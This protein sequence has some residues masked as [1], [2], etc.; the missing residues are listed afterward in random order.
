MPSR[1][2]IPPA[3][4]SFR[5]PFCPNPRCPFH[6]RPPTGPWPVQ[7]R[8]YRPVARRPGRIRRFRCRPCGAWFSSS[9][10][11]DDYW[12]KLPDLAA[13]LYHLIADGKGLRQSA[14]ALKVSP[15]T[16]RRRQRW[17]AGQALLLHVDQE[18]RLHGR[19]DEPVVLDGLRS[20]AGSQF[21]M[22]ELNTALTTDTAFW[23]ALDPIPLRRSGRMTARQRQQRRRRDGRLGRPDPR[24]RQRAT[25]AALC[26]LGRLLPKGRTLR[27]RTD[28]EPD[29]ARAVARLSGLIPIRHH[30]VSSR[31]RRDTAN[32]LWRINHLHR[33]MRH[34]LA[35]LKRETIAHSKHLAGL[36]DRAVIH[37]C[38]LNNTKGVTERHAAGARTTPAMKLG[39]ALRRLRGEDLFAW[40][41]FPERVGLPEEL[42]AVYE[43]S[44]KA[45]PRERVRPYIARYAY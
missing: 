30:T 32:P 1:T 44:I 14:R 20:F 13:P 43:G 2:R 28:E 40:R 29:Y 41:R 34:S 19:L 35:N 31:R 42:R 24:A 18:R 45:R 16:V 4:A 38:W 37:R 25:E 22:A 5:P 23:L 15:T 21:E 27:L 9:T 8:G 26:R 39:L 12:K 7:R 17:L 6:H 33:V 36:M 11:R 3:E 10:F